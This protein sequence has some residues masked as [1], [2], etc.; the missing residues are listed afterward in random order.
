M[1]AQYTESQKRA[2]NAWVDRNRESYNEYKK[3]HNYENYHKHKD[4][5]KKQKICRKEFLR[6]GAIF[7]AFE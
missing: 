1:G 3:P 6:L 5:Y 4:K 7:D 2:I